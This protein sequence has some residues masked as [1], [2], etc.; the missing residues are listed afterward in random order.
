MLAI[1]QGHLAVSLAEIGR[2]DEARRLLD[3]SRPLLEAARETDLL[4]RCR[5]LL[6]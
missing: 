4:A 2:R 6:G 5:R 3:S 1:M